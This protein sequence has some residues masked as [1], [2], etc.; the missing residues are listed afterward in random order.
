M[1]S[2]PNSAQLAYAQKMMASMGS[3]QMKKLMGSKKLKKMAKKMKVD[4]SIAELVTNKSITDAVVENKVLTSKIGE[5]LEASKGDKPEEMVTNIMTKLMND[6]SIVTSMMETSQKVLE[7]VAKDEK[8]N[9]AF[10]KQIESMMGVAEDMF[11]TSESDPEVKKMF[12]SFSEMSQSLDFLSDA[13]K[14]ARC[15]VRLQGEN[16]QRFIRSA[17][18]S[19]I[20]SIVSKQAVFH[21]MDSGEGECDAVVVLCECTSG[22][23][24]RER[25]PLI[26]DYDDVVFEAALDTFKT[27]GKHVKARD[28]WFLPFGCAFACGSTDESKAVRRLIFAPSNRQNQARALGAAFQL[29]YE[30]SW[31][32]LLVFSDC[33]EGDVFEVRWPTTVNRPGSYVIISE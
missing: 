14:E 24:S 1:A 29:A 32:K 7:E 16:R 25:L 10:T 2:R 6:Q 30:K 23:V 11:A 3:D 31:T 5:I 9:S 21:V 22:G 8:L 13:T 33:L 15:S 19:T 27:H 28:E 18:M 17:I 20:Q 26:A 4:N 12:E